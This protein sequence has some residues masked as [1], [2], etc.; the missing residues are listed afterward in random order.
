MK[1]TKFVLCSFAVALFAVSACFAQSAEFTKHMNKAK[2][3]ETQKKWTFALGE[4]YDALG[5]DDEMEIKEEA[6][7]AYSNL[8]DAIKSGN[9]GLGKYNDFT[10]HDE[11][12]NLLM[13]A[14]KY[15]SSF[16]IYEL[17]IGD[18]TRGE[19]N[20]ENRTASYTAPVI[21]NVGY[22][23]LKTINVVA[24]G[25]KNA[26]KDDWKDL[27]T[28]NEGHHTLWPQ[29]SVSAKDGKYN[30]N[31]AL[32]FKYLDYS[33]RKEYWNAFANCS[34]GGDYPPCYYLYDYKINIVDDKGNEIVKPKRWLLG[35][36]INE[37]KILCEIVFDGIS[38]NVM[39]LI[40]DGKAR[41]NILAM[42]LAYGAYDSANDDMARLFSNKYNTR[43][44]A[45]KLPEVE[46]PIDK[47]SIHIGGANVDKTK[48]YFI[49]KEVPVNVEYVD[50][51]DKL[52]EI[53]Q[54]C[55]LKRESGYIEIISPREN[56]SSYKDFFSVVLCNQLSE[57]FGLDPVYRY[58][59]TSSI[60]SWKW[61][62]DRDGGWKP[63]IYGKD[64]DVETLEDAGGFNTACR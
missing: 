39:E 17:W 7:A 19:L 16:G 61:T 51:S 54:G 20:Y 38:P 29:E 53:V 60:A 48:Q 42:Y 15:G 35:T 14:E 46:L 8:A 27:P 1:L 9:P 45:N 6:Y 43:S 21:W 28:V 5:T 36:N 40:D 34:Q 2:E 52:C 55:F 63:T 31:G 4:Y 23:Y 44:F 25:Y 13:D 24:E 37:D 3:Y 58:K 64:F 59:G 33:V 12:K 22:K 41:L 32:I 18:L 56:C 26:Y 10:I 50:A 11:W 47:R 49:K 30:V 57:I 62:Y